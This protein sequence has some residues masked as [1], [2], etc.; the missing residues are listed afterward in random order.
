[1]KEKTQVADIERSIYDFKNEEKDV[2]RIQ[3]G[4]TPDIDKTKSQIKRLREL[5]N[6]PKCPVGL[7]LSFNK[8]LDQLEKYL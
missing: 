1:M 7:R 4:L 6:N 8:T 3:S 2:Y 5:L